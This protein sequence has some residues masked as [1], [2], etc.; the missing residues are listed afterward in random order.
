MLELKYAMQMVNI[1]LLYHLI[2]SVGVFSL[3][4]FILWCILNYWQV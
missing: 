2:I 4:V 1:Q 3:I